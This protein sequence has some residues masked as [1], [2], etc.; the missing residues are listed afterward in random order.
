[1]GIK[2]GFDLLSKLIQVEIWI[3]LVGLMSTISFLILKKRIN[4][5]EILFDKPSTR[6]YN[7]AK[8]Q[9]LLL[10]LGFVVVYLMEVRHNLNQCRLDEQF[11]RLPDVQPE[12]L[13]ILG[14]SN[15]VY[16]WGKFTS[17]IKQR[18]SERA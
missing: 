5:I 13:A 4:I 17:L 18:R 7:R 9:L 1:M 15:F 8:L 16:L 2:D 14:G 11:C 12:Y 10:S 3:F 6:T